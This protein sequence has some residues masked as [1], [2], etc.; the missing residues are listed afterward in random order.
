MTPA[1]TKR[2]FAALSVVLTLAA[3]PSIVPVFAVFRTTENVS[4]TNVAPGSGY[5]HGPHQGYLAMYPYLVSTNPSGKLVCVGWADSSNT[6]HNGCTVVSG[7]GQG[8]G[9]SISAYD[10]WINADS[11]TIGING[12]TTFYWD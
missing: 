6:N 9:T 3:I 8:S 4:F 2:I 1:K 11:V 10:M 12:Q 7:S 5:L